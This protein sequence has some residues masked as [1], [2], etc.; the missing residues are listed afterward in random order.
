MLKQQMEQF[1][2]NHINDVE[3]AVFPVE[4]AY[5]EKHQ[6]IEGTI[7]LIEREWQFDVLERCDKETEN[8]LATE[9]SA[10]LQE[11]VSF[12]KEHV[13]Q[14]IFTEAQA[15]ERIRVDA[16]ALEF[17]D[18]FEQYSVLFGLRLQKKYSNALRDALDEILQGDGVKYS[19]AFAGDEGLWE[20]NVMLNA[21]EGFQE[22]LSFSA[23]YQL[24]YTFIF[25]LL[26]QIESRVV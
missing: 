3:W 8:L 18:I 25:Q 17:D 24:I 13:A 9:S 21:M 19:I 22:D 1:I 11:K 14:F 15:F 12:L 20:V 2:A 4:R 5:I 7:Q 26:E 6:L 10:F 16:M 23:C